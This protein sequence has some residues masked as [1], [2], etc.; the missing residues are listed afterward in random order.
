MRIPLPTT[1]KR[2]RI[3]II[4]LIDIVFFLLATF[5]MISLSMVKYQGID[6]NLPKVSA[7]MSDQ[8]Q[9]PV[10]VTITKEGLLYLE[11]KQFNIDDLKEHLKRLHGASPNLQIIINGDD[12]ASF[13]LAVNVFDE[14][15]RLGI[16]KII[17]RTK[18]ANRV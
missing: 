18:K 6:V 5:V 7:G 10:T 16:S 8:A 17:I 9:K 15:R 13:G 11:Q 4:P 14:I 12:Q 3:E 2:A 1:R